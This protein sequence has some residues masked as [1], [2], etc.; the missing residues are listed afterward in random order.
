M[1]N[2][3]SPYDFTPEPPAS[4]Q[5]EAPIQGGPYM[6]R[7]PLLPPELPGFVGEPAT[8]LL[9][10]EPRRGFPAKGMQMFSPARLR[11]M[12]WSA[13]EIQEYYDWL[14]Q[15]PDVLHGNPPGAQRTLPPGM[16]G[17]PG[18]G[19]PVGTQPPVS[20]QGGGSTFNALLGAAKEME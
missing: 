3:Y 10:N 17:L 16:G 14:Q 19:K 2:P 12:G 5:P 4:G 6:K 1:A 9:P 15:N 8:G 13:D 11:A 18:V 7:N 20:T